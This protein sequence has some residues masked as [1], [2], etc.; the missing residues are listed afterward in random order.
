MNSLQAHD[1]VVRARIDTSIK[2]RASD[3]LAE[4]GLSLSDA[5]RLLLIRVAEERRLRF[6]VKVPNAATRQAMRELE[7]GKGEKFNSVAEMMAVLDADD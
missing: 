1:S 7:A 3:A 4:M 2:E 5:I 6:E